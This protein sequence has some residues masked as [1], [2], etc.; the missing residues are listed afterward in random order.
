[1]NIPIYQ[2]NE[3]LMNKNSGICFA[4]DD[5]LTEFKQTRIKAIT[6]AVVKIPGTVRNGNKVANNK[7]ADRNR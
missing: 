4:F 1:M 6:R 2:E 5:K 7:C 3:T